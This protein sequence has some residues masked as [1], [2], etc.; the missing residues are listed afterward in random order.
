MTPDK[1]DELEA[2]LSKAT[3]APWRATDGVIQSQGTWTEGDTGE[4][5]TDWAYPNIVADVVDNWDQMI[6]SAVIVAAHNALPDLIATIRAQAEE[7]ERLE[8]QVRYWMDIS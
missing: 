3:A 5:H 2:L 8:G 6:N 4:R 7:I 1:L